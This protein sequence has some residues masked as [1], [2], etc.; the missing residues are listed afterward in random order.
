MSDNELPSIASSFKKTSFRDAEEIFPI[1]IY[2]ASKD[3]G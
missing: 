1:L 2:G 3:R